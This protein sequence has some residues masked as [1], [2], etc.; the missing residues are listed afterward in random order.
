MKSPLGELMDVART[1]ATRRITAAAPPVPLVARSAGLGISGQIGTGDMGRQMDQMSA[2]GTLYAIVARLSVDTAA[3]G[4]HMHRLATRAPGT[5]AKQCDMCGEMGCTMVPM[6]PALSVLEDPVPGHLTRYGLFETSQQHLDLTGESWWTIAYAGDRPVEIWPIRPDRMSPIP[7]PDMFVSG[8]RYRSPSGQIVPL[9]TREVVFT[10]LP[11]PKDMYRGLGPVQA[12]LMDLDSARYSA[13]WNRNF[14]L[15]DATPGGIIQ[16]PELLPDPDFE[17]LQRHWAEQHK[18]ISNAHRVALLEMGTWQNTAFSQRDMQFA[19]L[20]NLS[21]EVI[22]EAFTVHGHMLGLTQDVNLAN[23]KTAEESNGRHQVLPRLR[24]WKET[25][26]RRFLPLFGPALSTGYQFAHD[27][28][29]PEDEAAEAADLAIRA[30]VF[31]QLVGAGV[32]PDSAAEVAG[33]P[34]MRMK[35]EASP[36]APPAPTIPPDE[37]APDE[38][39]PVEEGGMSEDDMM[40]LASTLTGQIDAGITAAMRWE[41]VEILDDATCDPCRANDGKLYRNREDA[42]KDYPDGQGYVKCEGRDNCRG[43]VAKRGKG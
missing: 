42:Y 29:V 16:L 38:G 19:E 34:P 6:H 1:V 15:N 23:A 9:E 12:L 32:D 31:A 26:N 21:R 14:F 22:R 43:T 17:R 8:Y 27:N 28:P 33:L 10:K 2:V 11:N 41:A 40:D 25:L 24:R 7:D 5:S 35:V 37:G 18:G 20:R 36:P 30:G 39:M 13:E 3:E 4:W